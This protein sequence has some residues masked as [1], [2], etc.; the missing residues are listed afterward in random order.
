MKTSI[1]ISQAVELTK[2]VPG[3]VMAI[4]IFWKLNKANKRNRKQLLRSTSLLRKE[5]TRLFRE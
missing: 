3:A 5:V 1:L 2:E 4:L